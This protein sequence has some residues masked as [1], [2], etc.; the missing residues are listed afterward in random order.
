MSEIRPIHVVASPDAPPSAFSSVE[1]DLSE[2]QRTSNGVRVRAFSDSL[3]SFCDSCSHSRFIHSDDGSRCL[4]SECE[5]SRFDERVIHH[6]E[7]GTAD[8]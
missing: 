2:T 8:S 7:S 5:C 3:R 6:M 1:Q 4:Y